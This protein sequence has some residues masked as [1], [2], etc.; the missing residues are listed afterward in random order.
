VDAIII[1]DT[2]S[3]SVSATNQLKLI[4]DGQIAT[5]QVVNNF[6][7]H[8][9]RVIPPVFGDGLANWGSALKLNGIYLYSFL[10]EQGF[11]VGLID[12]YFQEKEKFI[13]MLEQ[14]PKAVIIS[15]TFIIS[16]KTLNRLVQDIRAYA[17][18]IFIIAGGQFVFLSKRIRERKE[19]DDR[20]QRTFGKEYIFLEEENDPD[21]DF[22]IISPTGERLLASALRSLK[23][24]GK[25]ERLPN[26]AIYRRKKY[27]FSD[28]DY[29]LEFKGGHRINWKKMPRE[30]F[31]AEVVPVQA[32]Y[33]CPYSCAFC[34]F[35][36]DK[37]LM[38]VK[39]L[40]LLLEELK[41][42]EEK[43]VRYIWFVDDNFRLGRKDLDFVCQKFLDEGIHLKWKS[44]IRPNVLKDLDMKL[45]KEAGCTEVQ[46]GL[47]S[48]DSVILEWMNKKAYP[49]LYA[50]VIEKVLRAD[51]N[52]SCYF[53]FGFPGETQ[54]TVIKTMEFIKALEH[55]E[56]DGSIYFTMFPFIIAPLSPIAEPEISHKFGLRG[57]MYNW[58]HNTMSFREAAEYA[59]KSFFELKS[60]GI[61]YHGDNLDMLYGM[62]PKKKKAF[63]SARHNLAK[64]AAKGSISE[65]YKMGIFKSVWNNIP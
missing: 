56:L 39:P 44:F 19:Y 60:S 65:E 46:F 52:C 41:T 14:S 5:I 31:E 42:I 28:T 36:K 29:D 53:I 4:L 48:A 24:N 57:S 20:L 25:V 33:G 22:Y 30:F 9:G 34:N 2:G 61:I 8:N 21:I 38:G 49:E 26:S 7:K 23:V 27:S 58:E 18:D 1:A 3:E 45:L 59:T 16:K 55:P 15:T 17:P 6:I 12:S 40:N 64:K 54:E 35:M 10:T 51:I 50:D 43:G 63:I 62:E 32:S 37:R 47:E 13:K 11:E